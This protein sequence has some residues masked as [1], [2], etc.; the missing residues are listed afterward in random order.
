M[1]IL[2][3]AEHAPCK[4]G[5]PG[6]DDILNGGLPRNRLYLI[7]GDPGVGKTTLGLQFLLEGHRTGETVLYV[8]L[9]E[10]KDELEQVASSHGWSLSDL[11][12]FELSALEAQIKEETDSS[13]FSPSEVELHRTT[14]MLLSEVERVKPDRVV[15]DSLSELRL[16]SETP[17]RYRRQV[18]HLKQFF[19]GRKCTALMLDDH[20]A[21]GVVDEQVASIAHGVILLL[22]NA[23]SYGVTRRHLRVE[24]IRGVRF[25]EGTHDILLR[26]GGLIV[27][28]RLIASEHHTTFNSKP[29]TSSIENLDSLLGGGLDPGTNTIFMGPSGT[30]KSSLALHFAA[31]AAHRGERVLYFTFDEVLHTLLTRAG[32]LGL[33]IERFAREKK[34]EIHQIDPA[35]ISPGELAFTVK[36]KVQH[37]GTRMVIIDSLNGLF[38]A[39]PDERHLVLQLHELFAFLNQ[40]GVLTLGVLAQQGVVG[41][42]QSPVDLTYLAD[43]VVF[44]RYFELK[45]E[46]RQVISVIKKRSGRHERTIRELTMGSEGVRVGPPLT[47]LTGVLTGCP[48]INDAGRP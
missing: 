4:T 41:T 29:V 3:K 16:L 14:K 1:S 32:G 33:P 24:K 8:T 47:G 46:V 44:L 7:L 48:Q 2:T 25:R 39:M 28:P 43:A 35:E 27:F 12:V 15:F 11:H 6:L 30:G 17:L 42:V 10:T 19:I 13:F 20:T 9:S 31:A 40:Q 36:Q 45:G 21:D 34:I 23:P 5:I 26:T 38:H 18:L 37:E 22:K